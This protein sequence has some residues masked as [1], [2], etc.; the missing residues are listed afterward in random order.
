M[1]AAQAP[2]A[3][4]V[5]QLASTFPSVP[6]RL[7]SPSSFAGSGAQA[8][9]PASAGVLSQ[10]A[11]GSAPGAQLSMSRQGSLRNCITELQAQLAHHD[12]QEPNMNSAEI[13][14]SGTKRIYSTLCN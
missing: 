1:A 7:Y 6:H 2:E 9:T 8:H 12:A 3:T 4:L 5:Q 10:A 11:P 13:K 14:T